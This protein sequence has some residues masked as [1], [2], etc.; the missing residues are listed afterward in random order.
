VG[1]F[2]RVFGPCAQSSTGQ[3][4][5]PGFADAYICNAETCTATGL[6][7]AGPGDNAHLHDPEGDRSKL[8]PNSEA[9]PQ[10]YRSLRAR[11]HCSNIKCPPASSRPVQVDLTPRR[12]SIAQKCHTPALAGRR[13]GG[14][15]EGARFAQTVALVSIH[16]V[17]AS[18]TTPRCRSL[19]RTQWWSRL[20]VPLASPPHAVVQP[21]PRFHRVRWDG[22]SAPR[23]GPGQLAVSRPM[24]ASARPQRAASPLL[25]R[26]GAG[27]L[28][29]VIRGVMSRSAEMGGVGAGSLNVSAVDS[30]DL[31][32]TSIFS[33]TTHDRGVA[34]AGIPGLETHRSWPWRPLGKAVP[35]ARPCA[36]ARP[37]QWCTARCKAST[38]SPKSASGSRQ[39]ECAWFAP[40]WVL[41]HSM[42]S[43]GPCSR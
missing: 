12:G 4:R 2:A 3:R 8:P 29:P 21:G 13:S 35:T 42:S 7:P 39:T 22:P 16:T 38:S 18:P 34:A 32:P 27:T 19:V 6:G 41:S 10:Q 31:R 11:A 1:A 20:H 23:G 30:S 40:R 14:S 26:G 17:T 25:P 9:R 36:R 24:A 43:R 15:R 28:M 37:C 33:G 5:R